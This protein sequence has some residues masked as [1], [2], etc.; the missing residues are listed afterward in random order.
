[1][2]FRRSLLQRLC[3][4]V[5][6]VSSL[7]PA[8]ASDPVPASLAF[9]KNQGQAHGDVRYLA[10]RPMGSLLLAPQKAIFHSYL[11]G[12][13][14]AVTLKFGHSNAMASVTGIEALPAK[15]NYFLGRRENW[16]LDIATYGKV[17][18]AGLYPGIDA[19]FHAGPSARTPF[20]FDVIAGP[21]AKPQDVRL[22]FTAAKS[23]AVRILPG[24]DLC[25]TAGNQTMLFNKPSAWQEDASG[26]KQSVAVAFLRHPDDSISFRLGTY[27]NRRSLTIDPVISYST[28][29]GGT[30][31]EGIF[32]IKRDFEGN[33]YVAGETSSADFPIAGP[34][35]DHV[36]GDYDAFISKFDPSGTQLIYSTYLGGSAYENANA[37]V[38]DAHANVYLTGETRSS[39]FPLVNPLIATQP[40]NYDAFVAALDR[41]GSRLIFSTYLGG[42]GNDFPHAIAID[43]RGDIYVAGFTQ[44]LDFPTTPG[45]FQTA[46]ATLPGAPICSGDA[47]VTKIDGLGSQLL[48][49][50]YLGGS[51]SDGAS[52][53]VVDFRGH[54]YI[55][56]GTSSA[57]FPILAPYSA[58][59]NGFSDAFIAELNADGS[60]LVFSTFFGGSGFDGANDIGHDLFGNIYIAGTTGSKNL[61]V[62]N[63]FQS[64]N[65]GGSG[66]AFVAK[67]NASGGRLIYA[68]Y[69]G[70]SGSE[71]LPHLA[72]DAFGSLAVCGATNSADFP[73]VDP[74]QA[75]YGGGTWD[76]FIAKISPDGARL[77]YAT[78]LGAKG[79]DH[80]DTIYSDLLGNVWVG[81]STGSPAFPVVNGYLPTYEGGPY[82]GFLTE[83]KVGPLSIIRT[84]ASSLDN[85]DY[86]QFLKPWAVASLRNMLNQVAEDLN[87]GDAIA[88][89]RNLRELLEHW[90]RVTAERIGKN[91]FAA[92]VKPLKNAMRALLDEIITPGSPRD[93]E[94]G[95]AQYVNRAAAAV[96]R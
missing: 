10:R 79:D 11:K 41:T 86:S 70:G 14:T 64:T 27:D 1:M 30:K 53:L 39:D 9:E 92:D 44:S 37:L 72:I 54:A 5:C 78:Y 61:P 31:D 77:Q 56:G 73:T 51:R 16:H 28:F 74:I 23:I 19:V 50:T 17:R 40:G 85:N 93:L 7:L 66:D 94:I 52:G 38:L 88:A 18:Y 89:T 15:I 6:F 71:I 47:F 68:S 62:L 55:A 91:P 4:V 75:A 3:T 43:R 60:G 49:S 81:G 48:Y 8:F 59:L 95:N 22:I 33:I 80:P 87:D 29:L 12:G 67:F 24:G 96:L 35:Q 13:D 90:D 26:T 46:C 20:E 42:K 58:E 57:D 34:V 32:A 63:A 83:I 65:G 25:V 82:D 76:L 21:D 2:P 84:F 69:L 36:A 45:A